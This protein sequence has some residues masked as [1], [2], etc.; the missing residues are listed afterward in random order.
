MFNFCHYSFKIN[1]KFIFQA[2]NPE[3]MD[4]TLDDIFHSLL[5]RIKL[6]EFKPQLHLLMQIYETDAVEKF[7]KRDANKPINTYIEINAAGQVLKPSTLKGRIN[8]TFKLI[9]DMVSI[10]S[11]YARG[12]NKI[13]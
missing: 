4:E 1:C 13:T 3:D 7:A 6:R 8:N 11:L 9:N 2:D 10:R 5:H 12:C